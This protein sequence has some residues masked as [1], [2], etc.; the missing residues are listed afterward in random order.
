MLLRENFK[1]QE[2]V[3]S[4]LKELNLKRE[5]AK[6]PDDYTILAKLADLYFQN[7]WYFVSI[8]YYQRAIKLKPDN[9]TL[10]FNLGLVYWKMENWKECISQWEETLKL[11]PDHN[12][13]KTWLPMAKSKL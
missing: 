13:A 10:H 12:G 9:P 6:N 8:K 4:L 1:C 3:L 2:K 7:K 5:F 11:D